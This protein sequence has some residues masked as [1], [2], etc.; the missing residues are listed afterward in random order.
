MKRFIPALLTALVLTAFITGC[1]SNSTPAPKTQT[2]VQE[3]QTPPVLTGSWTQSNIS[4]DTYMV[5]T[6]S[7]D[8]IEINWV[9]DGGDTYALYW[10]GSFVAPTT[11]QE[12]YIWTSLNDHDKTDMAMLASGDDTKQFTYKNGEISFS[13]SALGVTK[14]IRMKK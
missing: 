2:V 5:A 14:T 13:A 12:P 7:A 4:S 6:V 3:P 8:T 9:S 1:S 10:Y 11:P